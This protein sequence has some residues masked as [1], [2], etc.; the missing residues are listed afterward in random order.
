MQD[1]SNISNSSIDAAYG[2]F[3]LIIA[4]D[5]GYL[6]IAK[7]I[8]SVPSIDVNQHINIYEENGAGVFYTYYR[9]DRM[10]PLRK[11]CQ[12]GHA[13]I[14][15]LLLKNKTLCINKVQALCLFSSFQYE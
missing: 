13:D 7:L 8:L 2:V 3:P 1:M 5:F 10:T 6:E 12:N 11:A 14:V 15:K 9:C 4:I